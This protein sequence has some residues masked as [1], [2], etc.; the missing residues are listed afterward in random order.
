[1]FFVFMDF[2]GFVFNYAK[3]ETRIKYFLLSSFEVMVL[4]II[5]DSLLVVKNPQEAKRLWNKLEGELKERN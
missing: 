1:M 4:V 2:Y 5:G 3:E